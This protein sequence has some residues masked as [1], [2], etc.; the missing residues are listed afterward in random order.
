MKKLAFKGL[1]LALVLLFVL[2]AAAVAM[3]KQK[4]EKAKVKSE[5]QLKQEK[6]LRN[7]EITKTKT[8]EA[9]KAA[10]KEFKGKVVLNKK[11]MKFD[12]P[13]VIKEGRTLIPVRAI[14]NGFGA[15]V[16]WD[17]VSKAV[18]VENGDVK[19]TIVVGSLTVYVNDKPV[20]LDVPAQIINS[21]TFVPLRFLSEALGKKVDYDEKT[22]DI[23]IEEGQE[24]VEDDLDE[25]E[26]NEEVEDAAAAEE[27]AGSEQDEGVQDETNDLENEQQTN[28]EE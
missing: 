14:M 10:V 11:E 7:R 19:I 2:S 28:N 17:E 25:A 15:T 26:L 1:A 22:G 6:E 4:V 16:T 24:E 8:A 27:N 13:P 5:V 9:V 23:T 3:P 21:R 18:Y 12:V 20:T